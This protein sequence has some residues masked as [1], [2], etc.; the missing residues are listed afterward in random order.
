MWGMKFIMICGACLSNVSKLA[1]LTRRMLDLVERHPDG[2]PLM[3]GPYCGAFVP[4]D[5]TKPFI[6]I[7][8]KV[9][10]QNCC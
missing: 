2:Q 9:Y 10:S 7:A 4:I 5:S 6:G 8:F 1:I 3:V